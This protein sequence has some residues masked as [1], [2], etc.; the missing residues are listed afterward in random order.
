MLEDL[1]ILQ[2]SLDWIR[3]EGSG[4]V[5]SGKRKSQNI[6][7]M[8]TSREKIWTTSKEFGI[9]LVIKTWRRKQMKKEIIN[10][11]KTTSYMRKENNHNFPQAQQ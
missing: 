10:S 6:S 1:R 9:E 11:E 5:C 2:L 4:K 3:S 8:G 7:W